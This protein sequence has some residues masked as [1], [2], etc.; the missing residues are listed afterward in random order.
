MLEGFQG[1]L[2]PGEKIVWTG[3]PYTGLILRPAD[4]LL[5][6]FSLLWGGFA[7]FWN[8]SVWATKAPLEFKLFGLPFLVAGLYV[9][10]GRFWLDA[11]SRRHVSYAV[12][13]RRILILRTLPFSSLKSLDIARLPGLELTERDDGSGTIK[14][15]GTSWPFGSGGFGIWS[16]AFDPT[17]QFLRIEGVRRVYDL[18]QRQ[19]DPSEA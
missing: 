9:T 16:P 19:G 15:G 13:N 12:T 5:I 2:L 7:L 10:V 11:W 4:A 3:T 6:P 14:F 18:V 1:R 17:P 8:V